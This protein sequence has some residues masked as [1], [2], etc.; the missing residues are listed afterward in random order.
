MTNTLSESLANRGHKIS[1]VKHYLTKT[2][3]F[4]DEFG[5]KELKTTISHF[6]ELEKS[7]NADKVKIVVLGEFSRGKSTLLNALLDIEVLPM[8]M[9]ATTA[10]NTFLKS[11]PS[12]Q[13]ERHILVHHVDG[14]KERIAWNDD[15]VLQKWGTELEDTHADI[16]KNINSIEIFLD[17]DLLSK[18]LELIDTPGLQSV[19]KH[20][21]A[22]TRK[23]ISEAHI[24]IWLLSA[25]QLGGNAMEWNF[26]RKTLRTNFRKFLTVVNKW[27]FVME[28]NAKNNP[29]NP[30]LQMEAV[31]KNFRNELVNY[32]KKDI[33]VLISK[34]NL[35]GI[36]ACWAMSNDPDKKERSGIKKLAQ[37]ITDMFSSEEAMQEVFFKPLQSILSIQEDL[38]QSVHEKLEQFDSDQTVV[39]RQAEIDRLEQEIKNAEKE[40]DLIIKGMQIEHDNFARTCIANIQSSSLDVLRNLKSQLNQFLVEYAVNLEIHTDI[41]H[42]KEHVEAQIKNA[43]QT[44]YNQV[45]ADIVKCQDEI[46][47]GLEG[48]RAAYAARIEEKMDNISRNLN[49][50]NIK[51][52][53]LD[54]NFQIDLQDVVIHQT[55]IQELR[56]EM[57]RYEEDVKGLL[58]NESSE[59]PYTQE[60]ITLAKKNL[61]R[62]RQRLDE[63]GKQP[64]PIVQTRKKEVDGALWG[65]NLIDEE[66][67]DYRPVDEWKTEKARLE[68]L[69]LEREREVQRRIEELREKKIREEAA[70]AKAE[71]EYARK[72]S[73]C[74]RKLMHIR[75]KA[76]EVFKNKVEDFIKYNIDTKIDYLNQAVPEN[77]K[78]VFDDQ[79]Q[80]LKEVVH[81][82]ILEPLNA[83]RVMREEMVEGLQQ[84]KQKIEA[85]KARLVEG[86]EELRE[87]HADTERTFSAT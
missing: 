78:K 75:T 74:E 33:D 27:D 55:Q 85:D 41:T 11:L 35:F 49:E 39:Q 26:L 4:F 67:T 23:A 53:P 72:K 32:P 43:V 21:E 87:L 76:S 42:Q 79:M 2:K 52:K 64:S 15:T 22:I 3:E 70:R 17:H 48:L 83:K 66:Y 25:D 20:H 29:P 8:A 24:A 38:L 68:Q 84:D 30:D 51:L 73:D 46:L 10:I 1:E 36:S 19:I 71:K 60:Q 54:F 45:N 61:D 56:I 40:C 44:A 65:K 7:L 14:R 37:R 31:R 28:T 12:G 57:R 50:L 63:I 6:P 13:K 82:Q 58:N 80:T 34:D 18:G 86:L 59:D 62:A 16:R 81:E 9:Q 77:I 5:S 47:N 69:E